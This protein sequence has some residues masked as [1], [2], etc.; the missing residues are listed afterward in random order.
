[1]NHIKICFKKIQKQDPNEYGE[2]KIRS[3]KTNALIAVG[4]LLI[5]N[6]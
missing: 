1:M 4:K 2:P 5:I 3:P 6:C